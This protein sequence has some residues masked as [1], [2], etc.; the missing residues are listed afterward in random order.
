MES[1]T[2][3]FDAAA[4]AV[5]SKVTYTGAGAA[6]LGA[7]TSSQASVAVGILLGVAAYFTNLF[8]QWRRDRREREHHEA[9]MRNFSTE[10]HP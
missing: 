4:S 8:F 7:I 10:E 9:V 2:H 3:S 5:A 6:I 1:A